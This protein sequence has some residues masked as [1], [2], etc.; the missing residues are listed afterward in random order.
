[1]II[2]LGGKR[3]GV[4]RG[5]LKPGDARS[6]GGRR[7]LIDLALPEATGGEIGGSSGGMRG[8]LSA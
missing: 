3:N 5:V 1:M 4:A 8:N 6:Q 2:I 7:V